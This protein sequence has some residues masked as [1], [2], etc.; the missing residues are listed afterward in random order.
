[1]IYIHVPFCKSF[2]VY[3]GFYSEICSS[4]KAFESYAEGI[5]KEI[6]ERQDEI[7]A[8]LGLNTLYIGG[9]TPSV[10][11]PDILGSI[12]ELLPGG[13]EEFTFEA[14]PDDITPE[15]VKALKALGVNRLS[16]GVQSFDDGVLRLM[17]RRHDSEG[18]VSAVR[19]ARDGGIGNISIDLIFGAPS[20]TDGV[21]EES[22][23]TALE[24]RPNHISAYQL[25][26]EEGSILEERLR[27]GLFREAGEEEC[28]RQYDTLCRILGRAGYRHYE[29]SNFALPGFEARHNGAYW[30]RL[31]YVGLGPGA[32]S[33]DGKARR[34]W[35][36]R[37]TALWTR[38]EER[39]GPEDEA[40]ERIM[41]ALRTDEGLPED[42]LLRY[43]NP[44]AV[45][46]LL[47]EKAL[48]R[49]P[50]GRIRIPEDRFF[51]CDDIISSLI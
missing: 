1:M 38:E 16:L 2:C 10:L 29:V 45:K 49:I 35:N 15:Y 21:W 39:L 31:P 47:S 24:L 26:V 43:G 46:A 30:K 25:S 20:L 27:K 28:R 33:F 18:A 41:L 50:G 48:L 42:E 44:D 17:G 23:R 14:N 19:T 51:V 40:A 12:T 34:S 37:G 4:R 9:G 11:P 3:C 6:Q 7:S 36:S 32:H 8:A 22:L 5:R 13:Y